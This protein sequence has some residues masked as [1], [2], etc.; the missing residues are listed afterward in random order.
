VKKPFCNFFLYILFSLSCTGI[1]GSSNSDVDTSYVRHLLKQASDFRNS[2]PDSAMA[3]SK[4]ALHLAELSKNNLLISLA[5]QSLGKSY[6]QSENFEKATEIFLQALKIEENRG[7]KVRIA[8]ITDDMGYIYYL[9]ERFQTSLDYYN[10]SLKLYE[11]VADSSAIAKVL[12]HIGSLHTSRKFCETR[13]NEQQKID[14]ETAIDY[15]TVK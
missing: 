7:N 1:F 12:S 9:M 5:L 2:Y 6:I 10:K 15:L 3:N 13:T 11:T 14:H 8:D 4:K